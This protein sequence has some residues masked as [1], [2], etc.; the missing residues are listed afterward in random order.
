MS[1]ISQ[2]HNREKAKIIL[3]EGYI[4]SDSNTSYEPL[5]EDDDL[6]G[7]MQ[8]D[9]DKSVSSGLNEQALQTRQS[10]VQSATGFD[11]A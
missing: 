7:A 1:Q 10:I 8:G 9:P 11:P 4:L 3:S 2:M 6:M 5:S